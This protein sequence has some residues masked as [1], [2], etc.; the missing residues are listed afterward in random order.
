MHF[1]HVKHLSIYFKKDKSSWQ[2]LI[3]SCLVAFVL[4][5]LAALARG[6]V[7]LV[8]CF[9]CDPW[10][11]WKKRSNKAIEYVFFWNNFLKIH[12]YI[13]T[14]WYK[15]KLS[16]NIGRLEVLAGRISNLKHL[17]R[18]FIFNHKIDYLVLIS[19]MHES[20]LNVHIGNRK[21]VS[22]QYLI[23]P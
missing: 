21:N 19:L 14:F 1:W 8:S 16:S 17:C 7:L 4:Y 22:Y 3:A 10:K 18:S 6:S 12:I 15:V 23:L 9:L 2:C 5:M 20:V 11:N 13:L